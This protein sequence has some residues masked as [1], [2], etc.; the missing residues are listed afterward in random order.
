MRA[1]A[2]AADVVVVLVFVGIGRAVHSHGISVAGLAS[3][4]WPFLSGLAAGWLVVFGR[5]SDGA[6]ALWGLVVSVSTVALG[7]TLRV[8]SGQGTAVAFV[9]VATCF[10]GA[11]M[12]GW[13]LCR[14]ALWSRHIVFRTG[15]VPPSPSDDGP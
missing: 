7:M 8:I 12:I 15:R 13:R 10:L 6:S 11:A 1:A 4:T 2:V 14:M 5:R 9:I 3:T